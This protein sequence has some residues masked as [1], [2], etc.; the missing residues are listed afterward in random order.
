MTRDE[1][2]MTLC[3]HGYTVFSYDKNTVNVKK[4]D[5]SKSFTSNNYREILDEVLSQEKKI[6]ELHRVRDL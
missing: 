1:L 5:Y 4:G 3:M 2:E 6:G